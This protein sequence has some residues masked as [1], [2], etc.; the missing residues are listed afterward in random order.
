MNMQDFEMKSQQSSHRA[1]HAIKI[2]VGTIIFPSVFIII[3]LVIVIFF[4]FFSDSKIMFFLEKEGEVIATDVTQTV[5]WTRLKRKRQE[6]V[7]GESLFT[8]DLTSQLRL[9][10]VRKA[11]PGPLWKSSLRSARNGPPEATDVTACQIKLGGRS[12]IWRW[13]VTLLMSGRR[14]LSPSDCGFTWQKWPPTISTKGG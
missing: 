1:A 6:R 8:H 9:D 11:P 4:T 14:Q 10:V 2:S 5:E 7:K 12:G 13:L 3:S